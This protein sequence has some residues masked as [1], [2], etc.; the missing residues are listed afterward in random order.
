MIHDL[1]AERD[2][3]IGEVNPQKDL[4]AVFRRPSLV[5]NA[6]AEYYAATDAR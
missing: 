5:Q 4:S 1:Q 3:T 6:M 2:R